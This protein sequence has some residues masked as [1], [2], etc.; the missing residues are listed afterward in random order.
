LKKAG[1]ATAAAVLLAAAGTFEVASAAWIHAKGWLAQ[2]LIAFAWSRATA[3]AAASTPW[4]GADLKPIA[5]LSVPSKGVR[6]YV[7]DEA[8]ARTLAFGPAHL[9]NTAAPGASGNSVIVAHRDTHFSFLRTLALD[10]AIEVE[11]RD[12][13]RAHYRVREMRV[14]DKRDLEVAEPSSTRRL[15][16]VTCFPFDAVRPGTPLRYVVVAD[17]T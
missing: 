13:T 10:D 2:E 3:D 7:L 9:A 12:G 11:S 16:L 5:R 15:T 6:V 1:I 14:V 4:P 8:H 17:S